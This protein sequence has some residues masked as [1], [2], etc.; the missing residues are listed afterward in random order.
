[1]QPKIF[2][3]PA[4][5]NSYIEFTLDKRTNV[6]IDVYNN[7]G[8]KLGTAFNGTLNRGKQIISLSHLK[9]IAVGGYFAT[10]KTNEGTGFVK[11]IV[12]E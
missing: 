12:I 6:Q 10:I 5:K 9:N 1:M 4:G 8:Q 7:T 2:P 11:F 3:N